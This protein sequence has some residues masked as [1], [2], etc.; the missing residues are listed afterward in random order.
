MKQLG[1]FLCSEDVVGKS[2]LG[3]VIWIILNIWKTFFTLCVE[4]DAHRNSE[5]HMTGIV[6]DQVGWALRNLT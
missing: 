2:S 5:C 4:Q 3:T 1:P 6:K